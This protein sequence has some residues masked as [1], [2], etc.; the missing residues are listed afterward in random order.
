VWDYPRPPRLEK[1]EKEIRVEFRGKTIAKTNKAFRILETSHPPTYYL[2]P[3]G[4][5]ENVLVPS[6][7][8]SFC[9]YKG[10]AHYLDLKVDGVVT[11]EAAWTYPDPN[12]DYA[13]IK[14]YIAFY[15]SRVD[16]CFVDGE[17]VSAQEGDFYGGWITHEIEGP[18]KGGPG[19][20]GW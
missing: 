2:P 10:K 9:E 13:Q 11:R 18:L 20:E 8:T 17:K 5:T 3:D 1:V 15:P 19:T 6:P 4:V 14:D 16:G 12:S 7:R